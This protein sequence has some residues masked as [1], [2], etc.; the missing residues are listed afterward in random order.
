MNTSRISSSIRLFAC[1][2]Y[3]SQYPKGA[4]FPICKEKYIQKAIESGE[5]E[6]LKKLPIRAAHPTESSF[7]FNDYTISKLINQVMRDGKKIVARQLVYRTLQ[8]IK[9]T[10]VE[11]YN[12]TTDEEEKAKI[13]LDPVRILKMAINNGRPL[14]KL[15][16][17]R[18]GGS[19]YQIPVPISNV[20]ALS[21]SMK[22]LI[23][24]GKEKD[25][26]TRFVE[27]FTNE[28]LDAAHNRGRVV[29]KKIELH[30]ICEANRAYAHFRWG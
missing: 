26:N 1:P 2:R 7:V 28:I 25:M 20:Q 14:L 3:Y 19:I 23:E 9:N 29:K 21:L 5:A 22:W 30:K 13:I 15:Q 11:L 17:L 18:R 16:P 8:R 12:K 4:I 27:K 6:T 24:A 10:Q